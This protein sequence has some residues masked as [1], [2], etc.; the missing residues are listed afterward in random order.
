MTKVIETKR[1][2]VIRSV[3]WISFIL[4]LAASVTHLIDVFGSLERPGDQWVAIVA[5]LSVDGGIA[6]LS[7]AWGWKRRTG[8]GARGTV[9]V[10]AFLMLLSTF[11]N[12]S[13]AVAVAT[14]QTVTLSTFATLDLYTLVKVLLLSASLPIVAFSLGELLSADDT[15]TAVH[16]QRTARQRRAHGEAER[17]A[18]RA[19]VREV[20][21]T[22]GGGTFPA[23]I[24]H[25]R[26]VKVERDRTR[27]ADALN[28]M[29]EHLDTQPDA[30]VSELVTLTGRS[31]T[32]I[33][34]Y[35][36]ELEQSGRIAHRNGQV[37]A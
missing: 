9:A 22:E 36:R 7:Y 29:V 23:P 34:N 26:R 5:A 12:L 10:L 15:H 16:A 3:L 21:T 13:H 19:R 1:A 35:L 14:G 32:T 20:Q 18:E 30:P 25:A 33:Y 31:R 17:K 8:Q 11:A 6:S 24:E 37:N 27:K 2:R 28:A 4:A